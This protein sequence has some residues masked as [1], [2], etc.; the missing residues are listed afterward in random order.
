MDLCIQMPAPSGDQLKAARIRMG[1]IQVQAVALMGYPVQS[2]TRGG[3][4]SRT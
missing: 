4:Q 3:L 2:G 1:L